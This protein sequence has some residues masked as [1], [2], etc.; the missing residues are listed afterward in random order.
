[1]ANPRSEHTL[2]VLLSSMIIEHDDCN[3]R[4]NLYEYLIH[5]IIQAQDVSFI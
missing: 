1:M 4:K 3:A 5:L 2:A